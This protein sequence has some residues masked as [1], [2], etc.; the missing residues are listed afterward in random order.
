MSIKTEQELDQRIHNFIERK[1]QRFPDIAKIQ[2]QQERSS[3]LVRMQGNV[4][5]L[6]RPTAHRAH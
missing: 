6:F 3:I 4:S 2:N 5:E 1:T